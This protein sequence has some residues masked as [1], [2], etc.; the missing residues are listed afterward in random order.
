MQRS[1]NRSYTSPLIRF[2]NTAAKLR[3]NRRVKRPTSMNALMTYWPEVESNKL[4]LLS[5]LQ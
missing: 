2:G 3:T 4:H 1:Q 5:L